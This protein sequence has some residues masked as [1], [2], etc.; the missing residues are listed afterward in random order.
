MIALI[1]AIALEVG[2]DG[3]LAVSVAVME[4]AR[5]EADSVGI[6]GD[7]GIMQLN[8]AYL[9]YFVGQYWDKDWVFD[10][11]TPYDNIYVGL[12]HLKY[13]LS[14]PDF[15]VWQAIMAYNCGE[16]AVRSGAPPA[17]SIEY[18]NTVYIAWREML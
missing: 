16:F 11:R 18:A 6:T 4:N 7:L 1:L 17:S 13:L 15:N 14:V 9:D 3:N 5:F 8:P 2:V 10:W 12:R